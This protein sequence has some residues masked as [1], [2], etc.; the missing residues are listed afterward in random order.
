MEKIK[1]APQNKKTHLDIKVF[2]FFKQWLFFWP[3]FPKALSRHSNLCCGA[4][5]LLQGRL[6]SLLHL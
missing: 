1:T 6:S 2:S 4:F 5:Q 3:L